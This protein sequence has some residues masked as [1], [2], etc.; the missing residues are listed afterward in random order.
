MP[1]RVANRIQL[2]AAFALTFALF[3]GE[4]IR[5]LGRLQAGDIAD[6]LSGPVKFSHSF[7]ILTCQPAFL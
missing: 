6:K 7:S 1:R 4:Q 3:G 2:E 5:F